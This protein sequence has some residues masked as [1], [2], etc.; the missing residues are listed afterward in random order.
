MFVM[1]VLE[2]FREI[3]VISHEMLK[4]ANGE[5]WDELQETERKRADIAG[6][7]QALIQSGPDATDAEKDEIRRLIGFIQACDEQTIGLTRNWMVEL[8]AVL[9]SIESSRKL[10][11]A[12]RG[13]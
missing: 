3:S 10:K 8:R 5:R 13:Q 6:K 12:Y 2:A 9:G 4:C 11:R 7:L 1:G